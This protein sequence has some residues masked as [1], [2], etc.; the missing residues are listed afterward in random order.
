MGAEIGNGGMNRGSQGADDAVEEG[1]KSMERG[2]GD[3]SGF[4]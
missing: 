3:C 1:N 4:G 2:E